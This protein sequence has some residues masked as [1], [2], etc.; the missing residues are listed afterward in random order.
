MPS[1]GMPIDQIAP[2]II[3]RLRQDFGGKVSADGRFWQGGRCPQCHKK[4]LW[5]LTERPLL[6]RCNHEEKCGWEASTRDLYPDLFADLNQ[7]FAPTAQKPHATA[8]AYVRLMRGLDVTPASAGYEQAKYW[9][10]HGDRGTATVRFWLD[11]DKQIGWEKFIDLVTVT[12]PQDGSQ[13]V[14]DSRFIGKFTGL[15]WTPPGFDPQPFEEVFWAEG[16]FDALAL[17][18][19][20]CKNVIAPL[21]CGNFPETL[22]KRYRDRNLT[23]VL[24]LDAD[25]AGRKHTHKHIERLK[26]MG[27]AWACM[28]PSQHCSGTDWNDLH[29]QDRLKTKDK[30]QYRF[31]GQLLTAPNAQEAALATWKFTGQAFFVFDHQQQMYLFEIDLEKFTKAQDQVAKEMGRAEDMPITD[32]IKHEAMLRSNS[33]TRLANCAV[34]FRY[35]QRNPVDEQLSY[36]YR[37]DFPDG[38]MSTG[39]MAAADTVEASGFRKKLANIAP[40]ALIKARNEAHEWSLNR[41][42]QQMKHI[43]TIPFAGYV[44]QHG[45]YVFPQFAVAGNQV[46]RRNA[47]EYIK[48]P[49]GVAIK[50]DFH[51]CRIEPNFDLTQYQDDWVDDLYAAWGVKG[52]AALAYWTIS[53]IT[54]QIRRKQTSFT[55]LEIVGDAGTGKS[56]LIEFL[57]R[58]F[59][60]CDENG[61][62]GFDPSASTRS[63]VGRSLSSVSNLP[64]VF[65]EADRNDDKRNKRNEFDWESL[66]KL[67]GGKSPYNRAVATQGNETFAPPYLGSL[68]VSQNAVVDASEAVLSRLCQLYFKRDEA[69]EA[70]FQA[71][72]RLEGM[73]MDELSGYLIRC[74]TAIDQI[75]ARFFAQQTKLETWLRQQDWC[76]TTRIAFNH[77]QL[78]AAVACLD[79]ACPIRAE[80]QRETQ[81]YICKTQAPERERAIKQDH[82]LVEQFFNVIQYLQEK[83]TKLDHFDADN[84]ELL[85]YRL[86]EVY[87]FAKTKGQD[88]PPQIELKKVLKGARRFV[89]ANS[90]VRS[91]IVFS[92]DGGISG[93]TVRCW[94]FKRG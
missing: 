59:G 4:S 61:Y 14:R 20:G 88:L 92:D 44:E 19:N 89:K 43:E 73:G 72:R 69:S 68:V 9:N 12:D 2:A 26:S 18:L 52:I 63:F 71:A 76:K 87:E 24:A 49:K 66:K 80:I 70:S 28:Q 46:Y 90:P 74:L 35:T 38:R 48:L 40:G 37:V 60:R 83:G 93:K 25:K 30:A 47:D 13:A 7:R 65:I 56:T 34:S 84:P 75:E 55:F 11:K 91:K 23:W 51:A 79:L 15:A 16:I 21:T 58:L 29:K 57:W 45:A 64:T 17:H 41:W 94:I 82:P 36:F 10:Q 32:E 31:Y 85:A 77:A 62:E 78:A 81:E 6:P 50:S 8:E 53:L 67:Y 27:Q 42:F 1:K 86:G 3:D 54:T 39:K 33:L 22:I 5:T